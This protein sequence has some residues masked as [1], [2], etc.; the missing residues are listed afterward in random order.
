[1]A[2]TYPLTPPATPG[3]RSIAWTPRSIVGMNQSPFTG[4]QQVYA[5]P[6]Q[7]L[8]ATVTLPPMTDAVA[9]AWQAFFLALNGREGTFYLGDSVRKTVLGNVT[10]TLT[11]D[12]GAVANTTTLP[13]AGATGTFA[14]GDWLQVGT[15][16]SARLHRVVQVNSSSAIDVFPRLRTAYANGTAIDYT[17][18]IGLFRLVG[19]VPWMYDSAKICDG[20]T[21][22][23]MEVVP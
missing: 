15:T 17:S 2:I 11:V 16:S 5:W 1:M 12:S 20:L 13:I 7:W 10:G 19:P 9:G 18:P 22:T 8:E 3:N 14:V 21:F 23:A 4:A 6:G